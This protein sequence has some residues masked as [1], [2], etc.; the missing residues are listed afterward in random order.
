[1]LC[2]WSDVELEFMLVESC[3][4]SCFQ[5]WTSHTLA[6]NQVSLLDIMYPD[7]RYQGNLKSNHAR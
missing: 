2:V 7:L 1:M 6:R 5:E 3:E 4:I